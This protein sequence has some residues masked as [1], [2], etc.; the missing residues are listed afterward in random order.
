M[1][2]FILGAICSYAATM[3]IIHRE[4]ITH[5]RRVVAMAQKN[6]QRSMRQF[7]AGLKLGRELCDSA[8]RN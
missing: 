5:R 3:H 2:Y 1:I 4:R 7:Q 6:A 8:Q